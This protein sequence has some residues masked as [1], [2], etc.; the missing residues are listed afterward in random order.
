MKFSSLVTSASLAACLSAPA[1]AVPDFS[2]LVSQANSDGGRITESNFHSTAIA[3]DALWNLSG[4]SRVKFKAEISGYNNAM[5]Y[6]H[7]DGSNET[8]LINEGSGP[9]D[10]FSLMDAPNN[11]TFF[12]HTQN[13]QDHKWY[14]DNSL[15]L[16]G[17][18]HMLAFQRIDDPTKFILFWDDQ[19]NGGDRDYNDFVARVD[20]VTP[21]FEPS[22]LALLGLGLF[23]LG[24][25]RRRQN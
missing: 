5:G 23:G 2:T 25:A 7:S 22:A 19:H 3:N 17:L 1:L 24:L 18:D 21:V 13:D 11:F 16:D 4:S 9:G 10:W 20:F 8:L 15:N 12:L 6:A 14:S